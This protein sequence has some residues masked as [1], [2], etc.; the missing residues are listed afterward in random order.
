MFS[1]FN[2]ARTEA[3]LDHFLVQDSEGRTIYIALRSNNG[4][5]AFGSDYN[6]IAFLTGSDLF[7]EA[8][9]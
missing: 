9:E 1:I 2:K 8:F 4:Q 7:E 3:A 5:P 6:P